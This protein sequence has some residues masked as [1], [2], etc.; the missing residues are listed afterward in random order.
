M[1]PFGNAND[2]AA[3]GQHKRK[4]KIVVAGA[5]HKEQKQSPILKAVSA[6]NIRERI[7][8]GMLAIVAVVAVVVFLFIL[9]ALDEITTL[10]GEIETLESQKI[11]IQTALDL[12]PGYRE[13]VE[14]AEKD[15]ENYQ[16]FYYEY[17]DPETID[18]AITTMLLNNELLPQNLSMSAI[19]AEIVPA[20]VPFTLVPKPLP[21]VVTEDPAENTNGTEGSTGEDGGDEASA[22][23]D[24]DAD[25]NADNSGGSSGSNMPSGP[26]A[27]EAEAAGDAALGA[28]D[29]GSGLQEGKMIYCYTIDITAKGWMVDF[30]TFLAEA[31]GITAMEV[32]S[33]SYVEPVIIT[34]SYTDGTTATFEDPEGGIITMQLKLYVFVNGG[35]TSTGE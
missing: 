32:V 17:M 26:Q 10:E 30:Y 28:V 9:P 14:A 1:A 31:K 22:A 6:L 2:S 5:I 34:E 33:Y 15:F 23:E 16:H 27:A 11:E 12:I 13:D 35:V 25:A 8:I 29:D 21:K 4:E 24:A 18:K 3:S 19:N 7:M 20:Y